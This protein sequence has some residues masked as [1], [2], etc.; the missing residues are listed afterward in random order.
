MAVK[1]LRQFPGK[2]RFE[3]VS[4]SD[5]D[6]PLPHKD[7]AGFG[8]VLRLEADVR[9]MD[10]HGEL[11]IARK[12][13]SRSYI[14]NFA[15]LLRNVFGQSVQLIDR[16]AVARTTAMNTAASSFA[17]CGLLPFL[18]TETVNGGSTG[19]AELSGAGMAIGDGVAAEVH[20]RSD[21]V[22][23]VSPV[24]SARNSVVTTVFNAVTTTLQV[25]AGITNGTAGSL[26]ITEIGMFM[27]F[28]TNASGSTD[29]PHST[30]IAYDGITST[31]VP[32]GGVIAPRYTMDF[33]V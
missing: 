24:V 25:T 16:T 9:V 17:G 15:R 7:I 12:W 20:T 31:P 26:N 22:N 33:P 18:L 8:H 30:L 28:F 3:K 29:V 23:R 6:A 11:L 14:Q 10:R 4:Q 1:Y 27:F 19:N 2:R 32:V 13:P 5:W 21:L